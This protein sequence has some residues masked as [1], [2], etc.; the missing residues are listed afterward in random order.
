MILDSFVKKRLRDGGIV[1]FAVAVAAIADDVHHHV[2]AEFRAILR[3]DLSDAHDRVGIFRVDVKNGNG[4]ALGDVRSKARRMLLH[5]AR[6]EADEIVDDDMNRAADGVGLQ[7]GQIQGFRPDA[8][9]RERGVT[10]HDDR[11]NF[12]ERFA[13][14]V[15]DR[16][17]HAVARL[18]GARAAHRNRIDRF[19]VAGIRNQVNVDALAGR[20]A[21]NAGRADVIFHV[22]RA[23]HAARID[24][25]KSGNHFM[26]RLARRVH[27][28]VQSSAMAH[29]HDGFDAPRILRQC[30]AWNR[31]AGS[32][33]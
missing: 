7:V 13:R 17:V 3:G 23:E 18:L 5:R 19:Q 25:F 2:A 14:A 22:A 28:H 30:P 15:N 1:D 29:R 12:I 27:H 4:L 31:A 24:V 8:L 10:V 20:G 9:P 21:V 16:S 33:R 26:R 32:A 11:P 6:G